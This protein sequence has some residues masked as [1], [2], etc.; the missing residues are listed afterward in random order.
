MLTIGY[1][2]LVHETNTFA[3][4]HT[5]ADAFARYLWRGR[6]LVDA[7]QGTATSA[8]GVIDAVRARGHRLRPL[9]YTEA[10]PSGIVTG[11]AYRG[12]VDQLADAV[13]AAA[14]EMDALV[15]SLHGAMAAEGEVSA[16][17]ATMRAIRAAAGPRL[18]IA[19]TLD[20]HA[21]VETGLAQLVQC[22]VGYATYPHVDSY[23]RARDAAEIVMN[24]AEGR[25]R[26]AAVIGKIRLLTVPQGQHTA[27][28]PM[29]GL[30]SSAARRLG[31]GVLACSLFPGFAY[32]D[33]P[34]L[35]FA[36]TA[37]VDGPTGPGRAAV[38]D[39]C[40]EA[41]AARDAFAVRNVSPD[42]AAAAV[43]SAPP[44]LVGLIDVGDNIGG[45]TPGD[46]T[47]VLAALIRSG[48]QR[49]TIA[50]LADAGAVAA[51]ERA[52]LGGA[53][54]A[55][56]GAQAGPGYGD[57]LP[58][59]G[60]VRWLGDGRFR[61]RCGYMTGKP[62]LPGR[63]AVIDSDGLELVLTEHKVPTW[64]PEQLRVLGIEPADRRAIVLKAAV[65]WRAGYQ[66]LVRSVVEVDTP[67]AC[68]SNLAHFAYRAIPRPMY[69]LDGGADPVLAI[70]DG[71]AG[72]P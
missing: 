52:G 9:L 28:A 15:V 11:A 29:A 67:G 37:V 33:A 24:A 70:G 44:G 22:V 49:G 59:R 36:A 72:R 60:T 13:R 38:R 32:T 34:N 14:P 16:D 50:T 12:L 53:F 27:R 2:G 1:C 47:V 45:G 17:L 18:P 39:L 61:Y 65:A 6:D 46:G 66:N 3:P 64:D 63:T 23:E 54:A 26:P 20:L 30:L 51:A 69:P 58:L 21:N 57:P 10:M 4:G 25:S 31:D 41:W 40:A 48:A 62:V 42:D 5:E 8:G 68:A 19:L 35:G 7:L 55:H 71:Q 56:V 43:L